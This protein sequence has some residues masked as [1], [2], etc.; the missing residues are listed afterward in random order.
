[1]VQAQ[2]VMEKKEQTEGVSMLPKERVFV[3]YNASFLLTGEYLYY[4]VYCID[5]GSLG[6]SDLSKVAYVELVGKSGEVVFRQKI[7]L[8]HGRGGADFFIPTAVPS[9]VYKLVAFTN[10]M[11]NGPI[12]DFFQAD[13]TIVN[14]YREDLGQLQPSSTIK[15]DSLLKF[16]EESQ[17][18]Y[19]SNET[20]SSI[21]SNSFQIS[22][23]K[24]YFGKREK[25]SFSLNSEMKEKMYGN[26]SVSVRKIDGVLPPAQP[27]FSDFKEI[28][29]GSENRKEYAIGNHD[30]YLPELRGE[31]FQGRVEAL[32]EGSSIGDLKVAV[33]IPGEDYYFYVARTRYKRGILF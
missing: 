3:H 31:L 5:S 20:N 23:N 18:V 1:M 15:K 25:V 6:F 24:Q 26:Y 4:Q 33:S 21:L 13:V 16:G 30:V 14:P 32:K 2:K 9:G 11:R 12:S 29:T 8:E 27:S 19:V 22:L 17:G 28:G 10:W 7:I